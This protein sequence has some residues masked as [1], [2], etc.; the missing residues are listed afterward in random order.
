MARE[1]QT[2]DMKVYRAQLTMNKEMTA[3]LKSFGVPFFGTK[4]ELIRPCAEAG[5]GG[6]PRDNEDKGT[7]DEVGLVKLQRKMLKYLEDLC[8]GES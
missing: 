1:L 8:G 4:T 6:A 3:T 7:I 2:F 5:G